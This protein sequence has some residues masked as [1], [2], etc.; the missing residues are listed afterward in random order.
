MKRFTQK[1]FLLTVGMVLS[2]GAY[3]Q[4]FTHVYPEVQFKLEGSDIVYTVPAWDCWY[5]NNGNIKGHLRVSRKAK[6]GDKKYTAKLVC[7]WATYS[8]N[9]EDNRLYAPVSDI[10]T[11]TDPLNATIVGREDL[12]TVDLKTIKYSD[13]ID[14][15]YQAAHAGYGYG[16]T[17]LDFNHDENYQITGNY[18]VPTGMTHNQ[19]QDEYVIDEIGDYVYRQVVR[20]ASGSDINWFQPTSIT[21]PSGITAI[22]RGA[23]FMVQVTKKV[24]IESPVTSIKEFNFQD[25]LALKEIYFPSTVTELMGSVLGGCPALRKISFANEPPTLTPFTWSGK[26]YNVFV[27][28][29]SSVQSKNPTTLNKCVISFPLK[30]VSKYASETQYANSLLSSPLTFSASQMGTCC[31]PQRFTVKKFD[32]NSQSWVNGKLIAYQVKHENV[33]SDKI[34]LTSID[35]ESIPA[36]EG[37]VLRGTGPSGTDYDIFYLDNNESLTYDKFKLS[38]DEFNNEDNILV[39]VIEPDQLIEVNLDVYTYF[40]LSG[41][42]FLPVKKDGKL[43][44]NKAYVKYEGIIEFP[45]GTQSLAAVLPEETGIVSH[46]VRPVQNDAFY[47]L[48]GVQ[49]KQPKKGIVIKNGKKIVI[50]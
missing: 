10:I 20:N 42:K 6:T 31:V 9:G 26:T 3:A 2:V 45:V 14:A 32:I 19:T 16:I 12:G 41:G 22:G 21:I 39:G 44:A 35:D 8:D 24:V 36:E 1:F 25:C 48:Q 46:E 7:R 17:I 34:V 28:T 4:D 38:L 23:F 50:K 13:I 47:T 43:G 40:I 15:D 29:V 11:S 37:V 18:T 49:V 33:Y 30:Y 5:N 27:S